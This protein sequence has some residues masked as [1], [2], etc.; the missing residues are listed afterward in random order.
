MTLIQKIN[1]KKLAILSASTLII[2]AVI[3]RTSI[4]FDELAS[5]LTE[6]NVIYIL[7]ALL[8]GFISIGLTAGRW[9]FLLMGAGYNIPFLKVL[10]IIMATWPLAMIPGRLGDFAR[11]Y[12]LRN[13]VP[14]PISLGTIIFEK[15]ID[16]VSLLIISSIGFLYIGMPYF[17][18]LDIFLIASIILFLFIAR[19]MPRYFPK[20]INAINKAFIVLD[21]INNH[22]AYFLGAFLSSI[23]NWFMSVSMVFFLFLAF[24]APV[25][26]AVISAYLPL[27]IFVGLLPISIAGMGTRDSALIAF[28]LPFAPAV[29]ILAVGLGYSFISYIL[30]A[31]LGIPFMLREIRNS[32][33]SIT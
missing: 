9:R 22:R 5:I 33:K 30:F 6:S 20:K 26:I 31:L 11:A 29:K 12:P 24:G 28:L 1:L 21:M 2:F 14:V 19:K 27:S 25:S 32:R 17:S 8:T 23:V 16:V 13:N 3:F 18:L 4:Q 10:Y 15:I 7:L